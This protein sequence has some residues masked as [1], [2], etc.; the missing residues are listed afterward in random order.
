VTPAQLRLS[1][2]KNRPSGEWWGKVPMLRRLILLGVAAVV[3][4]LCV[5]WVV[6][7]PSSISAD[8]LPAYSPDIANGQAVFNEG[9]CASCH[10][11]VG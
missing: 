9:G 10:A 7:I 4:G 1:H 6:T 3:A 8:A 2:N 11:V 5:F